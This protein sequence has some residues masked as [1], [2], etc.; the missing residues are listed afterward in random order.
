V[1]NAFFL[2][3]GLTVE[4]LVKALNAVGASTSSIISIL[5]SIKAAG[6]LSAEIKII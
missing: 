4:E 1:P 6:A 5:E 3:K 2:K